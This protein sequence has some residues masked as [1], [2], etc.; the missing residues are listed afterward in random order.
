MVLQFHLV[1]LFIALAEALEGPDHALFLEH[2]L[3]EGL[4]VELRVVLEVLHRAVQQ[5]DLVGLGDLVV[6]WQLLGDE[7]PGELQHIAGAVHMVVL[8]AVVDEGL[9]PVV[10]V[11]VVIDHEQGEGPFGEE[12]QHGLVGLVVPQPAFQLHAD[13][14]AVHLA[15]DEHLLVVELV[16]AHR[17]VERP[18][19]FHRAEAGHE[20]VA[21]LD[22][23][24]L[25]RVDE[26]LGDGA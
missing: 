25:R 20:E 22:V 6:L 5:V 1:A 11:G 4:A 19:Q 7:R 2:L 24:V 3:C 26:V 18:A 12:H 21:A 14:A 15:L 8:R 9:L 16:D 10:G 13:G 23:V 17:V